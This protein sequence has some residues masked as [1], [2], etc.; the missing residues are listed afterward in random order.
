MKELPY[1]TLYVSRD[2]YPFAAP[3]RDKSDLNDRDG[4]GRLPRIIAMIV[5]TII[6]EEQRS[7]YGTNRTLMVEGFDPYLARLSLRV[8]GRGRAL[9]DAALR[10]FSS[11]HVTTRDGERVLVCDGSL[12]GDDVPWSERRLRLSERYVELVVS[13]ARRVSVDAVIACGQDVLA[14]D[15]LALAVCETPSD[16]R[17]LVTF[18]ALSRVLPLSV[19]SLRSMVGRSARR[20]CFAQRDVVVNAGRA[21]V[22]FRRRRVLGTVDAVTVR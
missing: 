9:F 14:L 4:T 19:A 6:M 22:T 7:W 2:A 15:L 13:G 1:T 18:E 17:L 21:S 20:A 12:L 10:A 8:S 3:Y 11:M 5:A 16:R